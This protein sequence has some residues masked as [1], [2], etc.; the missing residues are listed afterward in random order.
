MNLIK[1]RD[2]QDQDYI[3]FWIDENDQIISPTFQTEAE[4]IQWA[5]TKGSSIKDDVPQQGV[6]V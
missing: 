6:C 4:A 1:Y 2:P 5:N 3:H